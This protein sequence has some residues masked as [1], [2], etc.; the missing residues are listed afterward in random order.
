MR[1]TGKDNKPTKQHHVPQ[2]YLKNFCDV[3]GYITVI[4]KRD[5]RIFSTGVRA[6][7]AENNFYTW[8]KL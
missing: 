2:V 8:E 7:G 4:D 3:H 5:L 1:K 6:V